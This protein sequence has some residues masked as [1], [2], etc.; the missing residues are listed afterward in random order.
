MNTQKRGMSAPSTEAHSEP[1][2]SLPQDLNHLLSGFIRTTEPTVVFTPDDAKTRGRICREIAQLAK[3]AE[4]DARSAVAKAN[5]IRPLL[6]CLKVFAGHGNWQS[7]FEQNIEP[8]VGFKFRQA[9]RY[10]RVTNISPVENTERSNAT[11]E[12]FLL[13][14]KTEQRA[15]VVS[16]Q[17][18]IR[19]D[20]WLTPAALLDPILQVLRTIDTDPCSEASERKNVPAEKHFTAYED[21]LAPKNAWSGRVFINRGQVDATP[22][23]ERAK[24]EFKNRAIEEAILL[25]PA[26]TDAPWASLISELPRAFIRERPLVAAQSEELSLCR[27]RHPLMLVHVAKPNRVTE[28]ANAFDLFH[29]Q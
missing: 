22:W 1:P 19:G 18:V 17:P 5:R 25:L 9:Q 13:S 28:F 24:A 10:M 12:T 2:E 26:E 3:L 27:L 8:L 16:K 21:G 7:Y 15:E 4:R 29:R 20:L 23:I 6:Q 11:S 14:G